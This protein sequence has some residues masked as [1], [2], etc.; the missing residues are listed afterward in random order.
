MYNKIFRR[1]LLIGIF[2][3]IFSQLFFSCVTEKKRAAICRTCPTHS[4]DS[5][6]IVKERYDSLI[7]VNLN[8][9]TMYW[10]SPC[11]DL[12]DSLGR[13]I[14]FHKK[15]IKNGIKIELI[16]RNDSL[17]QTASVDSA[18]V[19]VKGLNTKITIAKISEAIRS[20]LCE[21]KHHTTWDN[22]CNWGFVILLFL[23]GIV[24]AYRI[25]RKK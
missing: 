13:I 18:A 12:C 3:C 8:G 25:A 4:K 10:P 17:I 21:R 19:N 16:G 6:S 22:I 24:G 7:Y 15:T 2:T 23:L 5:I 20:V 1:L 14:P 11:A 9:D